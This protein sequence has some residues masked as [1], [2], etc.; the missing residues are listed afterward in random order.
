LKTPLFSWLPSRYQY[1]SVIDCRGRFV[2]EMTRYV[3]SG[4]LNIGHSMDLCINSGVNTE[5]HGQS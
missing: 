4:T 2:C 3:S 1:Y 5:V